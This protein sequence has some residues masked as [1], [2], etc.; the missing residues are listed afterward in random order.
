[1]VRIEVARTTSFASYLLF[2]FDPQKPDPISEQTLSSIRL[3]VRRIT[4]ADS[5]DVFLLV[6][7]FFRK[8]FDTQYTSFANLFAY[9][10]RRS[11][12]MRPTFG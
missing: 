3:L 7:L 6:F 2:F 12:Q 10:T 5:H 11:L 4:F 9:R 8:S 1:M